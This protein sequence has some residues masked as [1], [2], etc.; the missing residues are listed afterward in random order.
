[1]KIIEPSV[2]VLTQINGDEILKHIE[3]CG[4]VCYKSE[5]LITEDSAKKFVE[6]IINRKHESVIEHFSISVKIITDRAISHEL[7][8]HRLASYSQESQR[9]CG[10]NKDKFGGELTFIKPCFWKF[11]SPEMIAWHDVMDYIEDMYLSLVNTGVKPEEARSILPNSLK[12]EII[13]TANL[14]ELR[15]ILKLR[16]SK[17]AHPEMRKV[18]NM[19]LSKLKSKIPV[20]FDDIGEN[21]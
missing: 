2:E 4:R 8:R 21:V 12:T 16:T 1:M 18:M 5:N 9:Y 15:H 11:D 20:I 3:L 14:R 7:V 10:Y 17:V 6:N 13:M 19:L